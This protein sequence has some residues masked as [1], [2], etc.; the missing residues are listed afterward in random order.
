MNRFEIR[1]HFLNDHAR[2]RGKAAVLRSLALGVLRGD[3]ELSFAMRLKGRDLQDHLHRHMSW[4]E[5][6]LLPVLNRFSPTAGGAATELLAEHE[7]QRSRLASSLQ[8]LDN[9]GFSPKVL[10]KSMMELIV[11]IEGDMASEEAAVL[12]FLPPSGQEF[13]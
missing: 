2:L 12:E 7:I 3:E 11:W 1:S 4:E 6:K 9:L 5:E 8:S 13:D 10:A